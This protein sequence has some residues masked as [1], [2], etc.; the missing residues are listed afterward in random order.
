[1][2]DFTRKEEKSVGGVLAKQE[3]MRERRKSEACVRGDERDTT[4]RR[5]DFFASCPTTHTSSSECSVRHAF[6]FGGHGKRERRRNEKKVCSSFTRRTTTKKK[7][8]ES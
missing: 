7:R 5:R 3:N 1:M 2:G 6:V 4:E 8:R